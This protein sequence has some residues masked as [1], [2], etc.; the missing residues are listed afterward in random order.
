MPRLVDLS[1]ELVPIDPAGLDDW[2]LNFRRLLAPE[3]QFVDPQQ[4]A[5]LAMK[6]FGCTKEDLPDG[7]GWTEETFTMCTHTGTHVDAPYH[8]GSVS[9]GRPARTIEQL[10][11]NEL[12]A[13]A[14]V[15]DLTGKRGTASAITIDDLRRALDRAGHTLSPGD[16]VLFRTD[17]DKYAFTDPERYRYP[18][19][20]RDS[21]LWLAHQGVKI[22]GTDAFA[23]DRPF[24]VM[25]EEF[26][27]TGDKRVIWE[28]HFACR[29]KEVFV[30]Q[31]L[32][33]LHLL[34]P[35]GFTV[36]CFP[37]R[38]HGTSAAP[39]R[40]VAFLGA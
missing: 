29:E 6:T 3:I 33:N 25:A 21:V 36:G 30:V 15:L 22:M 39:A 34:P 10:D 23:F 5:L 4:G 1:R 14:V 12:F 37:I 16:A 32:V 26:R 24:N 7:E 28:G 35:H 2:I 18:G 17:H 19:M 11:L 9:E 8:A 27:R 20:I 38:L 31:Q 40:V 13:P